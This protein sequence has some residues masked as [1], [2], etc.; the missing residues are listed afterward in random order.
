MIMKG[1]L[2]LKRSSLQAGLELTTARS[3]DKRLTHSATGTP[4]CQVEGLMWCMYLFVLFV[5]IGKSIYFNSTLNFAILS[6]FKMRNSLERRRGR[7]GVVVKWLER[8]DYGAKSCRKVVSSRLGFAMRRLENSLCN[9]AVNGYLFANK[10]RLRQR[11]ERDGLRL[12]SAVPRYSGTLTP[13][14]PTAIRQ[15]QGNLFMFTAGR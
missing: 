2:R 10:G 1:C 13:T 4:V 14:A 5:G 9:P 11:K 15:S 8:L 6:D 3:A 12:S 7:R